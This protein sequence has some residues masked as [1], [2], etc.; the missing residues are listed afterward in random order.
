M[1]IKTLLKFTAAAVFIFR[2]LISQLL[3]FAA[4]LGLLTRFPTLKKS[5]FMSVILPVVPA[6]FAV[7]GKERLDQLILGLK[8]QLA[9]R[10][11][12]LAILNILIR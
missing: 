2:Y 5:R 6:V 7:I 4:G 10:Q 11:C 9:V 12:L 3:N 1:V 8:I